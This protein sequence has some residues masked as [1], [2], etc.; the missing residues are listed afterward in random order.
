M[1]KKP[2]LTKQ[3]QRRIASRTRDMLATQEQ[4]YDGDATTANAAEL[5]SGKVVSRFGKKALISNHARQLEQCFIRRSLNNLGDLTD[6]GDLV[7][8]DNVLF[9]PTNK[10]I[11]S[12][13]K[14]DSCL[15]RPD[16]YDGVKPIAANINQA[17][18]VSAILPMYSTQIIDRYLVACE[19]SQIEPLLCFNKTD[20]LTADIAEKLENDICRY[21]RLGYRTIRL[22]ALESLSDNTLMLELHNKASAFVGPSGV[23]KSTLINQL[24]PESELVTAEISSNSN[25]GQ[26]TTTTSRLLYLSADGLIIDSPG[27]REFDLW[28]LEHTEVTHGFREFRDFIG[29]C[30]FTDCKHQDDPGCAIQQAVIDGLVSVE[31]YDN[32]LKIV[33]SMEQRR[34]KRFQRPHGS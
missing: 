18:I 33:A 13:L 3:Q 8:G 30:K 16:F 11:E 34:P 28:H 22:S 1:A 31:R 19:H 27:I 25:L 20:L 32:Y 4:R 23:G 12:R 6:S 2:K 9:D 10:V 29:G 5:Q 17:V 21:Q 14:R 15:S 7:V 24:L 26:H